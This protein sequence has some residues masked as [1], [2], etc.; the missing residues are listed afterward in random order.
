MKQVNKN[1]SRDASEYNFSK[2]YLG[3]FFIIFGGALLVDNLGFYNLNINFSHIWPLFLIFIGFCFFTRKNIVSTLVGSSV[4]A[5]CLSLLF[6]SMVCNKIDAYTPSS[7]VT[8]IVVVRDMNVERAQINLDAA[9]GKVNVYSI[10]SDNLIEGRVVSNIIS[11]RVSQTISGSVQSV[12][13]NI[14]GEKGWKLKNGQSANQFNIGINKNIPVSFSFN[15][16]ASA[17]SINLSDIMAEAVNINAGASN[18]SLKLGDK[19]DSVVTIRSGASSVAIALPNTAGVEITDDSGISSKGLPGFVSVGNGVYRS[20]NYGSAKTKIEISTTM[21]LSSLKASWYAPVKKETVNL[22]FYN[23]ADD[24]EATC[25]SDF[26]LP[27]EREVNVG[28]DKIEK[29][30]NLLIKGGLTAQE[31]NEGFTTEFPNKDFKLLSSNLD[32]DGV[33]TLEFTEVPGFTTGGS[34]RVGILAEQ[35]IKTVKQFP[36]VK[37]VIFE[38]ESLFEP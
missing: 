17:D 34:C 6:V 4:F 15:G 14:E 24:E 30:I 11:S 16:G 27:I 7:K 19:V 22:Y 23:Q 10:N 25:D 31:K 21:G 20:D 36:E 38:P 9:A 3:F 5:L 29:A 1:K 37:K 18:I 33:L 26:V 28:G 35:I 32:E 2:L 12:D 8:P 13:I